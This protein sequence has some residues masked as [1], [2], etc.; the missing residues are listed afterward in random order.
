MHSVHDRVLVFIDDTS[1]DSFEA[2]ALEI[3]A[4]Q[5][6]AVEPYR[7]Y[8]LARERTPDLVEHWQD[9][10]P[11]PVVAFKRVE[12]CCGPAK[13]T[14]LSSGTGEGPHSRSRHLMPDLRLYERSAVA[15]MRRHLFP[16]CSRMRLVS[17]VPPSNLEPHSSL[18][19]MIS[20]AFEHFASPGS[21]FA[22]SNTGLDLDLFV[23]TLRRSESDGEPCCLMTTTGTLLRVLEFAGARGQAFRLP[24]G[25]RLMDTGGD[26]GAP[27]R[28][29]RRGLLQACWT[30]FGIPGYFCVNEYGMAELSSQF[31][32]N[33][34]ADRVAGRLSRRHKI[35]PPW[36]RSLVLDPASLRP[37]PQ[38]RRGLLCH[39]DL[40]N[41]GTAM[42]VLTEDIGR[43]VDGGLELLGRAAGA[44]SRGCSLGTA[45][46]ET[47]RRAG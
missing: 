5:F 8:C 41:A 9:I 25:S 19:Q 35:G 2:L 1:G 43:A 12:L 32:D 13:R 15:G 34:L 30:V 28:M 38:G 16:D 22:V 3:F 37:V 47:A 18:A 44:E 26:K 24:H 6:E 45:E 21:V 10:P 11:V 29:S 40:A 36:L 17:L 14:F 39:F 20:W 23:E 4:H 7:L 27:R 33:V 46:W 31:Y 42:A